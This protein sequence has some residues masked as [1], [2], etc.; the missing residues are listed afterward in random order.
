MYTIAKLFGK[1]PFAPLQTH[2]EKVALCIKQ[3][4]LLFEAIRKKNTKA[5]HS[6]SK[7]ISKLEHEAD[8]T[9]NDIR[10]H[11]PKSIFLPIDRAALLEI[12]SLQDSLADKAEDI[13]VIATIGM[14]E[15]IPEI[16]SDF[17]KFYSLNIKTFEK[18]KEVIKEFDSLLE[19]SFGGLEATKVKEMTE[20]VSYMEHEVDTLQFKITRHL[21]ELGDTLKY[22]VFHLWMSL[23]KEIAAISNTSEKL[24]NRVRMTLEL[25]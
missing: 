4:P 12:L 18:V 19:T 11:L 25:K 15:S 23:I 16:A 17:E 21:Y 3:L 5:I 10:N 9:K 14:L 6:I 22:P 1:S 7:K 8:L 13:G 24:A 20:K 2:M